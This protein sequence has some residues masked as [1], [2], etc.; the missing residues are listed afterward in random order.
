MSRSTATHRRSQ[1]R[2][3]RFKTPS[4]LGEEALLLDDL[5]TLVAL[6]LLEERPSPEGPVYALTEL[7]DDTPTFEP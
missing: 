7:G 5:V 4:P 1:P 2:A 3:P 6:G